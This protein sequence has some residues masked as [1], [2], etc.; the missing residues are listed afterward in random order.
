[1]ALLALGAAFVWACKHGPLAGVITLPEARRQIPAQVF[2]GSL[3][4]GAHRFGLELGTGMRTYV[5]SAAPYVLLLFLV[6]GRPTLAAALLAG[7]G[8]GVARA[9]PLAARLLAPHHSRL[10]PAS[11]RRMEPFA[12]TFA[13]LLILAGAL[14]L[15]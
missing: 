4:R 7:V 6:V 2:G 8:F 11:L 10:A 15:V 13:T 1:M 12:S 14:R 9:V 3:V 5:P